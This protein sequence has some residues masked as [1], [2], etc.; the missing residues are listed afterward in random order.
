MCVMLSLAGLRFEA[1]VALPVWFMGQQIGL[2]RADVVVQGAVLLEFKAAPR[3][4]P[5]HQAQVLNYL[6]ASDLEIGLILN[7]GPKAEFKRV[8]FSNARKQRPPMTRT[9]LR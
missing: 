9:D 2:F 5:W 1:N 8:V 6:R 7:F 4:E 3:I